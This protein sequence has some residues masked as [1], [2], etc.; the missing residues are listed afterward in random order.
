MSSYDYRIVD[1]EEFNALCN[2]SQPW[3]WEL[4]ESYNEEVT[5][6]PTDQWG[7]SL[8]DA[9]NQE[10]PPEKIS[11]RFF[12]VRM[13]PDDKVNEVI[14]EKRGLEERLHKS[15]VDA[16]ALDE[17][18]KKAEETVAQLEKTNQVL[19]D[20]IARHG[21]AEKLCAK[22]ADQLEAIREAI[23][24]KVFNETLEAAGLE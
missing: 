9:N 23:G 24:T 22:Q 14:Y 18:R 1:R 2:R 17:K 7:R 4:I 5:K 8:R 15:L 10:M 11:K 12:V 13:A 3:G 6:V 19:R 16:G 21:R 20:N